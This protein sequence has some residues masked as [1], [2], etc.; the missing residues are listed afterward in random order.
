ML[1]QTPRFVRFYSHSFFPVAKKAVPEINCVRTIG[2][3]RLQ[4]QPRNQFHTSTHGLDKPRIEW[5]SWKVPTFSRETSKSNG[6]MKTALETKENAPPVT[7]T[8]KPNATG[9]TSST[10]SQQSVRQIFQR[11]ASSSAAAAATAL[12]SAAR[13]TATSFMDLSSLAARKATYSATKLAGT[14][15]ESATR[16]GTKISDRATQLLFSTAGFVQK[17]TSDVLR[18]LGSKFAS[19]IQS[20]MRTV[21]QGV[22]RSI[23]NVMTGITSTVQTKVVKPMSKYYADLSSSSSSS[24]GGV[25]RW[26]WW[27]SLAAVAVYGI[28][29]TVPKELIR[30]AFESKTKPHDDERN[31]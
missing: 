6:G 7:E 17:K 5:P 22:Q 16:L 1:Q 27:W 2:R 31:E 4:Q 28:A 13:S 10:N 15:A 24:I 12:S 23:Q 8:A 25:A 3:F 9:D 19:M 30:V 11:V 18:S 14:A 21:V 26:L 20:S 29:T